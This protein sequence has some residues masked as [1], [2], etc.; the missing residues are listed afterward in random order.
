[1]IKQV[2]ANYSPPEL[3]KRVQQFWNE[4][5]A[6]KK[7][8]DLRASGNDYYFVDG[9]PY[10][11]GYIHL[12]TA[13]NK[14]IKDTVVRF[15]RMQKHNVRDQ[16][17]Y[18]MHGLPIEVKVEQSIGIKSKKDI[19]AYGIDRFVSTCKDYALG[20]QKK[21]TE[22][23][24]ELGV[25]MDWERP[26]MTI[27]PSYIEAA[28]WTLK[29]AHGQGLLVSSNRVIT[30]CPRCETALAE[31]EIE[32]WEEKDP[33]IYVKFPL[34]QEAGVS[35]LVWTTTPWTLPANMAVAAHPDLKYAKV[36]YLRNGG[37]E[38]DIV[39][40]LES[41]IDAIG[42]LGNWDEYDVLETFE[43]ADLVG[44]EYFPPLEAEVDSQRR[45][46]GANVHKVIPSTTVEADMTGLV[47]I[48]PGHG[49]EDFELGRKFGLEPYSPIDE[50][51]KFVDDVGERYAGIFVKKANPKI[52][53]D[54][55]NKGLMFHSGHIEHRYGHCWRC[56]SGILYR[57]TDQ[58]Y[59]RV[60]QV[61]DLML[62]EISK[63]RWT[64]DWA[65]SSREY[66]WTSNARDWC[67]SRQ[68]YWGIPL[69][70]W[71]CSCGEM[72]VIGSTDE[73]QGCEGYHQDMELHRPWIDG[74]ILKCEK[75]GGAM[76]RVPDV[77]DV[78]FDAGVASWAALGYPRNQAEFQRWWPARFI[79]EA[80]DQT[81]G[82]FYSQLGSSSIAFGRAP[83]ESVL[84][85]GWMLDPQGQAMH[86]S[87]G[88]VI[89]PGKVIAEYGADAMRFYFMRVS[90]PWEDIAFQY[91]GVKNARKT[92]NILW[93]VANFASTYMS[94]DRF[95]PSSVDANALRDVLRP[96]DRWLMSRT[97]KLK[98]EVT[99]NLNSCD[100]H[101]ACRALEEFILEDMSRWYV[102]LIRDRM[103]SESSDMDKI[104]AY[105]TLYDAIMTTTK[106]LAPFC[107]H[108]TEEIYQALDG[109]METV[110]M[111]DWPVVNHSLI[112]DRLEASMRMMQELVEDIT[113][114]RQKKNVKLRW[115]LKRIVV[116]ANS[117]EAVDLIKP[118]EDVLLSQGNVKRVEYIPVGT[119]WDEMVL[120]VQPNP[121]AIGKV[122]R[123][124]ASKIALMLRN[125]PAEDVRAAIAKGDY[126]LGIEG[127]LVKIEP[128]M[129][130]FG[131]TLPDNVIGV[132]F[133]GGEM[134]IDFNVDEEIEAE[135]YA[136]ELIRRIQQMRKDM[137]LDVEEFVR[138]EVCAPATFQEYFKVW[139][140]HIMKETRTMQMDFVEEPQGE[141]S[142][143]WDVEKQKVD[144]AL[145]SLH[146]K[147]RVK[148]FTAI[149]GVSQEGAVA[150]VKAGKK[151][152]EDLKEMG[153]QH[154]LAIPGLPRAD[155][156][157]I[158]VFFS[159]EGPTRQEAAPAPAPAAAPKPAPKEGREAGN[160]AANGVS[161]QP[162]MI[163]LI[164]EERNDRSYALF[165]DALSKGMKGFCVTR[166]YPAKIRTKYNL[167]DTPMIWLS[168]VGKGDSLPP[169]DLEK[170]NFALEQF[171]SKEGGVVLLDGLEYLITNNNFLTVL[172][173]VQSL[174]DQAAVNGSV[175][176][177]SL[178]P[179]TLDAHE[180]N[181][182]E[183]EAD[184]TL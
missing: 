68:R 144:I 51:G 152:P 90:A 139:K 86:K 65:G 75:C 174:K 179:S 105:K 39:I 55:Q 140:E 45:M 100:L 96:E 72:K 25:W 149:P 48:A 62:D 76:K 136:R 30:W 112:D 122:Y 88:N 120:E 110:H 111:S 168:S 159:G 27:A 83:Y 94:I 8:K 44:K 17:G 10:T 7:T 161:L 109:S 4:T 108:I 113:K 116:R 14:T 22:Q 3:E 46:Q 172:R 31:A 78:W 33:S 58:W 80:H 133:P 134:Y 69:P 146:L 123:Q 125:R 126:N 131:T 107:P 87:K 147:E 20:M 64:P 157:S 106:L 6:Y 9:P 13:W 141:H 182:L 32:Y 11:T 104:A 135:G 43:G 163:Y 176:L 160:K 132:Q 166:D 29:K 102:R 95:E 26:Y 19:E 38:S 66:D 89:E 16:P 128:N 124:W 154:L 98:S 151:C 34:K 162:S 52:I 59:L 156:R 130:S 97:E 40:I 24:K 28:W 73:L 137:K 81:R 74:V 63:V 114:E 138:A 71:Q 184:V 158:V 92:L 173:F 127:Q 79:T 119:D 1:M 170:L 67:I 148:N 23:F 21:M 37:K 103:W 180:L 82:W 115:P 56:N 53:E 145:T 57:N 35:L 101:K 143:S 47:H 99:R 118:M 91:E 5:D 153:E 54:L 15:K 85:H 150:L 142:A 50:G 18:D 183:K 121:N 2:Q 175:L 49:P 155:A 61:K 167:G 129:V 117:H 177:M 84:M 77:L 165:V 70:V 178:N 41:L 12:G 93:N 36:R 60:T 164:K 42:S 171:V 169:K 181:L